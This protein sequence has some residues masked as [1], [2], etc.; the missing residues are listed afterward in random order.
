MQI[1]TLQISTLHVFAVI[2][3]AAK[4]PGTFRTYPYRAHLSPQTFVPAREAPAASHKQP[5]AEPSASHSKT[6]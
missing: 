3:S 6:S 2:L 1:S 4:D 5:K